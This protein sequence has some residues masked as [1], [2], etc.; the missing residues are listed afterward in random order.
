MTLGFAVG[1]FED[2]FRA[3]LG[4]ELQIGAHNRDMALFVM[5]SD[6]GTAVKAQAVTID[7]GTLHTEMIE[8][9][10]SDTVLSGE[11]A[12][13]RPLGRRSDGKYLYK[14]RSVGTARQVE[15]HAR[16]IDLIVQKT[17]SFEQ[18]TLLLH[19][20]PLPGVLRVRVRC[21]AR[22]GFPVVDMRVVPLG[23]RCMGQPQAEGDADITLKTF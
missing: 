14:A 13:L 7:A 12:W 19:G 17:P 9:V 16:G 3:G 15:L 4:F 1:Q 5:D 20:K 23:E 8:I 11:R 6:H 18:R 10:E 2:G 21:D 22:V